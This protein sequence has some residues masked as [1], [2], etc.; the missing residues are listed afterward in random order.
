M[1]YLFGLSIGFNPDAKQI[2]RRNAVHVTNQ[3]AWE[4]DG[5][6]EGVEQGGVD[7]VKLRHDR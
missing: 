1:L 2:C 4:I 5:L 7:G 3:V 6:E